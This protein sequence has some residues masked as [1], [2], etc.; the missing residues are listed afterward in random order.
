MLFR[1]EKCGYESCPKTE[2]GIL[3]VHIVPHT[4][5]DVGWLKT[6]DQYYYGSRNNIQKAGVQ[7]I[8]DSVV[9]ELWKDPQR[10]FIYVETAFFWKWWTLQNED[11]K[12]KVKTLVRQGRLE[13]IGGA[14]SM[15]DEASVHYQ[16][17]IDQFTYGLR[18]LNETFGECGRPKVGWQIDP[19]GHSR[20]FASLLA[21]MAYDGLFLGRIDYQDKM[22]RLSDKSMEM[23]WRGDDDIGKLSDI[24]T[25]VLYNTYSPPSGFCFDVLCNDEP[26]IDDSQSPMYNVHE[27]I[28]ELL[29]YCKKQS[30]HY[31]SNNIVLTMGGDFT[32]QEAGMWYS[33]LDKM[34]L[35]T[36]A[37]AEKE[38]LKIKLF[39][40]TP[41]CYLKAVHDANVTLPTKRDD[42]FPYAS[43]STAYWT[44]YFTSRPTTKYFERQA[45][46]FLQGIKQLQVLANLDDDNRV[47][48]DGLSEA[49][50]VMQHH[51]AITGTEKQHVMHDYER[52]LTKALDEGLAVT[53]QALNKL[54]SRGDPDLPTLSYE[55][56]Q[57]NQSQCHV[58]ETSN[59]FIVS[60][61]NPLAWEVE[62]FPVRIPIVM[63]D[64]KVYGPDG[65]QLDTQMESYPS[66]LA[67]MPTRESI[68]THE[69]VF[70]A[71][72]LPAL[73]YQ[74]YFVEKQTKTKRSID[75]DTFIYKKRK[76]EFYTNI[77]DYWKNI[78]QQNYLD[79]KEFPEELERSEERKPI[80]D[81]V[82]VTSY[83][84]YENYAQDFGDNIDL[85]K[86]SAQINKDIIDI[87]NIVRAS[88]KSLEEIA[89]ASQRGE[90]V[91][92]PELN[93]DEKRMLSDD[94]RIVEVADDDY[95]ENEHYKINFNEDN[96]SVHIKN[97]DVMVE[98]DFWYYEACIG[99]N[100]VPANRSS[101][102]Y[103]F[104]PRGE[105]KRLN[106]SKYRKIYGDVFIRVE[107]LLDGGFYQINIFQM[108]VPNIN[109]DWTF[110]IDVED[111]IG[112]E[113]VVEYK[114]WNASTDGFYTDSNSR[115]M[116]KREL[117]KRPQYDVNLAEP[118]PGN[119]YPITNL[120]ALKDDSRNI[121]V[122]ILTDR[123]EGASSLMNG[124]MEVML[125]RRLLHD[126]AF[127]VGE[128]LNETVSGKP[129]MVSG[130]HKVL[131]REFS[132]KDFVEEQKWIKEAQ[133]F[134]QVFMSEADGL[135]LE[136]FLKFNNK[137]SALGAALPVGVHVLTLER[138]SRNSV[139]VRF[140]N[141]L[142]RHVDNSTVSFS[143]ADVFQHLKFNEYRETNLAANRWKEDIRAWEWNSDF[144]ADQVEELNENGHFIINLGPKQIRTF[145]ITYD[146]NN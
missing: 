12:Q 7:Y 22:K 84:N 144:N 30:R 41:S 115:Q 80:K 11:V 139:L 10:R 89:R 91:K 66:V 92:Y 98:F 47:L 37:K 26:I 132:D 123:S 67:E 23:I 125:H 113:I 16:S 136:G 79:I 95:F 42:F 94:P 140:E 74:Q 142:E 108:G 44:G 45:N 114:V 103:I 135:D 53:R 109:V 31:R 90:R 21:G 130:T 77:N 50:G 82:I 51:D 121:L 86:D 62:A 128:A 60:I 99:N 119:Y 134:P 68:A 137:F 93:E 111:E 83:K 117:N 124:Q 145:V 49:M 75:G 36:N 120:I 61:Y 14:W 70:I 143:I 15:N 20:E 118:I 34:I 35:H 85:L 17:T 97:H 63:G 4:H 104:R 106:I 33:N 127:G 138:W 88:R 72:K 3:N 8:L 122:S 43:D 1:S 27:R 2:E 131:T 24:F 65:E 71:R 87:E 5:D 102:A 73:G 39:Y 9:K 107:C 58:S 116:M 133:L 96:L 101:G 19:F 69:L 81:D 28:D 112:K 141:F 59:K 129:L 40:S 64:Y 126:D 105:K 38:D 32:Y 46:N 52:L 54:S 57:L 25:G 18:K 56:C 78:R 100:E 76:N 29:E 13:F 110:S 48:I 55:R 146:Y 6:V